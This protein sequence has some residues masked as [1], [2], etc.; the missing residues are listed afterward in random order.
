MQGRSPDKPPPGFVATVWPYLAYLIL[1][2]LLSALVGVLGWSLRKNIFNLGIWLRWNPWLVRGVDLWF[3]FGFGILWVVYIFG[4]EGYLRTAVGQ[5]RLWTK[6]RR[7]LIY[8]LIL[9]AISYGLQ[10]SANV[11]QF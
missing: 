2:V 8:I 1:W 4:V 6:A 10:F 11:L 9:L 7:A 5:K 3:I